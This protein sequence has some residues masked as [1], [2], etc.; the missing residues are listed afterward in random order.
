MKNKIVASLVV[1]GAMIAASNA[2]AGMIDDVCP[3]VGI[4]YQHVWQKGKGTF[5]PFLPKS[6]PGFSAYIGTR[7]AENWGLEL[8]F[9]HAGKKLRNA[10]VSV[11]G[12]SQTVGTSVRRIGGHVDLAGYLPVADC[13]E[14]MG[15]LGVGWVRAKTH[16]SSKITSTGA[17]VSSANVPV[18]TKAVPRVRL[19]FNYMVTDCVGLR[20]LAGW[21]GTSA[22][23]L[24]NDVFGTKKAFKSSATVSAGAFFK[25]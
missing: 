9:D 15:T 23:R 11:G 5:G 1:A 18:K 24:K 25:F 8:G 22:L 14:L 17:A 4:D 6:Y 12:V 13:L 2:N 3:V 7:W 21:E 19:G 20:A 10:L 16:V